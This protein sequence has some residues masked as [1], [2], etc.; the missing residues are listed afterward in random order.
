MIKTYEFIDIII[1]RDALEK[2]DK[3]LSQKFIEDYKVEEGHYDDNLICIRASMGPIYVEDIERILGYYSKYLKID[4]N[5]D[6]TDVVVVDRFF[7][8]C[9]KVSWLESFVVNN[10]FTRVCIMNKKALSKDKIYL[11]KDEEDKKIALKPLKVEIKH[12]SVLDVGADIIVNA[13]NSNLLPGGGVCGAIFEKAG[14]DKLCNECK[15]YGRVETGEAVIT[16]GFDTGADYIIHAVGPSIYDNRTDWQDK[17]ASAYRESLR[18]ADRCKNSVETSIAFP[19]IST[20]IY[21]CPLTESAHIALNVVTNFVAWDE[22]SKCYLCCYTE[23]EYKEYERIKFLYDKQYFI[24]LYN[25]DLVKTEDDKRK[26]FDNMV[27]DIQKITWEDLTYIPKETLTHIPIAWI[28]DWTHCTANYDKA[29]LVE[30]LYTDKG[31]PVTDVRD[32]RR[33]YHK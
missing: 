27:K 5:S 3:G 25:E 28:Q 26:R 30:K 11:T 20:G 24:D 7:G 1:R 8:I 10:N 32:F 12:A 9:N 17:L 14:Y 33:K 29:E 21:G 16:E 23:K 13:A 19:C 4:P 6:R 2:W 18:F 22:L 15:K 31:I